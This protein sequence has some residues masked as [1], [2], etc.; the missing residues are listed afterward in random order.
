MSML[1]TMPVAK[2]GRRHTVRRRQREYL[3]PE[4]HPA[5]MGIIDVYLPDGHLED[6]GVR[7]I[8]MEY[9]GLPYP[10]ST[11]SRKYSIT[12]PYRKIPSG[13]KPR[14]VK[15]IR[16]TVARP[17]NIPGL[18]GICVSGEDF[19]REDLRIGA[20]NGT[21]DDYEGA[22]RKKGKV[23]LVDTGMRPSHLLAAI[24]RDGEINTLD[25]IPDYV[26]SEGRL[27][28]ATEYPFI[29]FE[30]FAAMDNGNPV[31]PYVM[32]NGRQTPDDINVVIRPINGKA[33][34]YIQSENAKMII[35]ISETGNTLRRNGLV[36]LEPEILRSTAQVIADIETVEMHPKFIKELQGRLERG[37]EK[38]RK[39]HPERYIDKLNKKVFSRN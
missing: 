35:D 38:D 9:V 10:D 31:K 37:I 24:K 34:G 39:T 26:S 17:H 15:K 29:A 23:L 16:I 27:Y 2:R 18:S 4:M 25:E 19:F 28:V 6:G 8:W 14:G 22:L 7:N 5:E 12:V 13:L 21:M 33:E 30:M 36:A 1:D 3:F 32:D 11:D 20:R